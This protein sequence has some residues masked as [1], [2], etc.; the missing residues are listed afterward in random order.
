MSVATRVKASVFVEGIPLQKH[1]QKKKFENMT[2]WKWSRHCFPEG[3]P[4]LETS[5][6]PIQLNNAR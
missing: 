6:I 4:L 2:V 3:T 5:S 1:K